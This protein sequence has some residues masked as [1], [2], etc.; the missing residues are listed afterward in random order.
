MPMPAIIAHPTALAAVVIAALVA[1][2][3][4]CGD[5]PAPSATPVAAVLP[6]ATPSP[7]PPTATAI[8]TATPAPTAT[9]TNTPAATATPAPSATPSP[10][11]PTATAVPTAT[12]APS[13][14]ALRAFRNGGWLVQNK[15]DLAN[16]IGALEWVADGVDD[17]E[18]DGLERLLEM[19]TFFEP[20]GLALLDMAWAADGFSDDERETL[21]RIQYFWQENESAAAL[22]MGMSWVADG[23]TDTERDAVNS[24][25]NLGRGGAA[26]AATAL[27]FAW[28]ADGISEDDAYALGR[29]GYLSQEHADAA[30]TLVGMAWVADGVSE[31]E[32]EALRSLANLGAGGADMAATALSF[33]WVADGIS[34]GDAD[35]LGR[36][37]YLSHERADAAETLIG[38][39]WV[40]DGVSETE[41]K[42]LSSLANLGTGGADLAPK[43]L[44][45]AW[46]ADGVSD[47]ESEALGRLGYLHQEHADA[48]ET[49]IGMSWV[50]D[51]ISETELRALNSLA[52][53]G[54]GGAAAASK[55]LALSWVADGV[56]D[57]EFAAV[58]NI[59]LI[60]RTDAGAAARVAEMPF[61]QTLEAADGAALDSLSD[62]AYFATDRFAEIMSRPTLRDGAADAD[63]P[64][65]SMLF[66]TLKY[67]Q[68]HMIDA[69]FDPDATT[70]ER[71]TVDLPL[72]GSVEL[73]IV[74][75]RP[76]AGRGM[77]L[78][79]NAVRDSE[80]L[81]GAPFPARYVGLL[82]EDAVP[83]FAAGTNFGT[84]MAIR[85]KYDADDG[86]HY[87][88]HSP[89][90][91][92]HEVAHYYWATNADWIDEG[93]AEMTASAIE[94]RRVGTPMNATNA[95]C[96][97]AQGVM[98]LENLAP[99]RG[100]PAFDCNY[101]LGERLFVDLLRTMGEDAFWDGARELHAA[102]R[103]LNA[104][105]PNET[106]GAGIAD[107]R[108]AFGADS[109]GAGDTLARW[110]EGT[111]EY[112]ISG[113][114]ASPLK[115]R[116]SALNGQIT[117]AHVSLETGVDSAAAASF[118]PRDVQDSAWLTIKYSYHHVTGDPESVTLE[119]R[120]FYEDGFE[121]GRRSVEVSADPQHSGG[122]WTYYFPVG[123]DERD[124]WA[125]GRY[126][127]FVYE[128]GDKVAEVAYEVVE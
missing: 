124:L 83:A 59:S 2:A 50:A 62:I 24:L 125:T 10:I 20:A 6:T 61:L 29:F 40:A 34:A 66:G 18:R 104:A 88:A 97:F 116:F 5:S 119:I 128:D 7:I 99:E 106:A 73:V 114:D 49:L 90:I 42:A 52:N 127:A 74:R 78:L 12:P 11:P 113:L 71:R 60:A 48:A 70:S 85:P 118:S 101:S 68:P 15:P 75:S 108:Q 3:A 26:A 126:W 69:L 1:L 98:A 31:T 107:V 38:M 100:E 46:I 65:I 89:H 72:A 96:A 45:F 27:S 95:P 79:E 102:S 36:F 32:R 84:H 43:A 25:A 76:G 4:A 80:R 57:E 19:A 120:E 35:A 87:A 109:G 92:A 91:I 93:M 58:R 111:G 30:E 44:A 28:V 64:I 53:L 47:G 67:G 41:L 110:Y 33:A 63:A 54:T 17:S 112:D 115:I 81:M 117:G 82:Y 123:A 39:T 9:A 55:T 86:G 13:G 22:M 94:N 23:V 8:P 51:D 56:S 16:R 77:D 122:I 103:A 14:A 37:G 105:S 21:D 121:F